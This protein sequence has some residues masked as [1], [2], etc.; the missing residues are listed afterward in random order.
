M[1][2][3]PPA[4]FCLSGTEQETAQ[5]HSLLGYRKSVSLVCVSPL[6]AIELERPEVPTSLNLLFYFL[7]SNMKLTHREFTVPKHICPGKG[8]LGLQVHRP[9][10]LAWQQG[11]TWEVGVLCLRYLGGLRSGGKQLLLCLQQQQQL[12]GHLS[13]PFV[14]LGLSRKNLKSCKTKP[15]QL[16]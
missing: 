13:C 7:C 12:R 1:G 8:V 11:T 3:D 5:T 9:R 4:V 10:T 14:R 16:E 15:C 6:P 2:A